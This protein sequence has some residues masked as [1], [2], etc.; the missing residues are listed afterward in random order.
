MRTVSEY[1]YCGGNFA[2]QLVST[3]TEGRP[4]QRQRRTEMEGQYVKRGDE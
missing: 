1:T 2:V 4:R 3:M